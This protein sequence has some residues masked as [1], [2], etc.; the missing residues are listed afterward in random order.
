MSIGKHAIV[1]EAYSVQHSTVV[2]LVGIIRRGVHVF[3]CK[4]RKK[5]RKKKRKK[6]DPTRVSNLHG[7]THMTEHT[8]EH[9]VKGE[10]TETNTHTHG[11]W[12]ARLMPYPLSRPGTFSPN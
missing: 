8:H 4:K 11:Q 7:Q 5:E 1:C 3:T 12:I 2:Q 6:F 9:T 10:H